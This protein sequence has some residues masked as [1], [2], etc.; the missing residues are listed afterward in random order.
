MSPKEPFCS[1]LWHT[2]PT[3]SYDSLQNQVE[4]S[5]RHCKTAHE[6]S[7]NH[8]FSSSCLLIIPLCWNTFCTLRLPSFP[9]SGQLSIRPRNFNPS[10]GPRKCYLGNQSTPLSSIIPIPFY[11]NPLVRCWPDRRLC[12]AT[13]GY[14]ILSITW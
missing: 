8:P 10:T 7:Q 13:N 12:A 14:C 4:I 1:V 11:R 6:P 3:L 5:A 9:V 2:I